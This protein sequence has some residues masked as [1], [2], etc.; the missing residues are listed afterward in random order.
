MMVLGVLQQCEANKLSMQEPCPRTA[1]RRA[2]LASLCILRSTTAL[3]W[4]HT[5]PCVCS[6]CCKH[7]CWGF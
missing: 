3:C 7:V 4:Q 5:R 1:A 2:G 6:E